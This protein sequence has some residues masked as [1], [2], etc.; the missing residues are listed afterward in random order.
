MIE[1]WEKSAFFEGAQ[2][3]GRRAQENRRGVIVDW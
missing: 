3:C 2:F 1:A